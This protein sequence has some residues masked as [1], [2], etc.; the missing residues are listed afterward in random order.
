ME[1]KMTKQLATKKENVP[2]FLKEKTVARGCEEAGMDDITI[3][4]ILLLQQLSPE[5]DDTTEKY[6][7]DAKAGDIINSVTGVNYGRGVN[8]VPV[9]FQK[10]YVVFKD[11]Q[12]GGGF[13][14][15]FG[16]K[17]EAVDCLAQQD[18]MPGDYTIN[19][20]A[21]RIIL[22]LNADG[23]YE[24][25]I[26]RMT[27]TKL[28]C[29]RKWMSLVRMTEQDSF[30]RS[31]TIE[32]VADQSPKG[33]FANY[34]VRVGNYVTEDVYKAAEALYNTIAE[35]EVKYKAHGETETDF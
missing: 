20:T 9:Y 11:R 33:K 4:S 1:I 30:A 6:V 25:A 5:L 14:G 23:T 7:P 28:K 34:S 18:G 2:A 22:V 32:S 19:D 27:S 8:L 3:P 17:Q 26:I 35:G 31:Y 16:T 24:Q 10:Q 21:S 13:C 12:K 29:S 15:A